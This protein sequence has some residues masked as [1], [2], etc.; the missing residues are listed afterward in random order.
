MIDEDL[1]AVGALES[2]KDARG[3]ALPFARTTDKSEHLGAGDVEREPFEDRVVGAPLAVAPLER[4]HFDEARGGSRR[5]RLIRPADAP[6]L[7][8]RSGM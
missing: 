8:S 7:I 6:K 3:R 4:L 2:E 1:S 5:L